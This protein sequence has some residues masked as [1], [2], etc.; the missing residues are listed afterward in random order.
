[1]TV[2]I[3]RRELLVALGGVAAAWPLAARVQQPECVGRIG[4]LM[5][6]AQNDREYQSYLAA[7]LVAVMS[8]S[9]AQLNKAQDMGRATKGCSALQSLLSW[10]RAGRAE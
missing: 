3:R 1:M 7:A 4:V 10:C 8:K 9:L 6:Y 5:A 2:T